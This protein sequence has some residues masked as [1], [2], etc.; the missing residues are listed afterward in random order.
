[1]DG[2]EMK[3]EQKTDRQPHRKPLPIILAGSRCILSCW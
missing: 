3:K 2:T 1:M